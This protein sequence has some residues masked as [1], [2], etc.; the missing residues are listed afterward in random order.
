MLAQHVIRPSAA[1]GCYQSQWSGRRMAHG[2]SVLITG[3]TQ[4]GDSP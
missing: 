4:L 3:N 1:L 2:A